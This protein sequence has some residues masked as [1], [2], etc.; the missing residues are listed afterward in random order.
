MKERIICFKRG[1][2]NEEVTI[3]YCYNNGGGGGRVILPHNIK[4]LK[5]KKK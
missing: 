1:G 4:L 5:Y 2:S 3:K